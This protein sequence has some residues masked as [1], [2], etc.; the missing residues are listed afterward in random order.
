[1]LVTTNMAIVI[2]LFMKKLYLLLIIFTVSI[3]IHFAQPGFNQWFDFNSGASFHNV[4]LKE[5][6]LIIAGTILDQEAEQW[7]A[8]FLKMDTLG[9]ILDYKL[10]LDELEG[11]L[12]FN[13]GFPI[14]R[15]KNGEY[16][17]AGDIYDRNGDFLL[18]LDENGNKKFFFE[19]PYASNVNFSAP[20]FLIESNEHFYLFS[21]K[22]LSNYK[23][24]VSITKLDHQGNILWEQFYA[25]PY[26]D[27]AYLTD[28][29]QK[30]DNTFVIGSG[31][32]DFD[33]WNT[34]NSWTKSWI[35]AV[36]SLG[37]MLWEREN[38]EESR[39]RGIHQLN[40]G[41]WVYSTRTFYPAPFNDYL[42][43]PKI[44]RRDSNFNLLWQYEM[45]HSQSIE[46]ETIEMAIAPDGHFIGIGNWVVPDEYIPNIFPQEEAFYGGCLYKVSNAGDSLWIQCDTGIVEN[47]YTTLHELRGMVVL[48]SGSIVA[49]GKF[50][51]LDGNNRP[52][53]WVIKRDKDGCMEELC[54]LTDLEELESGNASSAMKVYPNPA[55]SHI[56]FEWQNKPWDNAY[57][58][59]RDV[60]G[61]LIYTT[62]I[63]DSYQWDTVDV[64]DGIYI[65]QLQTKGEL[66]Q[67]GRIVVQH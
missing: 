13:T 41:D 31:F 52:V 56:F 2:L 48:P 60:M 12:A 36:D 66:L 24:K 25:H 17:M 57:L 28:I 4:I 45:A 19:Y 16:L 20:K 64:P 55:S 18:W 34:E 35:F 3:N 40:N 23:L 61:Q 50:S 6:T 58:H 29:W 37:N 38:E 67:T 10:Y 7:G 32:A 9:N 15:I 65:Y 59:I 43:K 62:K 14:I 5:D 26:D 51:N 8:L 21:A 39:V 47:A 42:F 33:D 30:D 44:V 1:V 53:G 54:V 11:Q 63:I 46:N 22:Q 49:V 27:A